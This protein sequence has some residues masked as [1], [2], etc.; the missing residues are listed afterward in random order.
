MVLGSVCRDYSKKQG[1]KIF[2]QNFCLGC[3]SAFEALSL[4]IILFN[5]FLLE[6]LK[7]GLSLNLNLI[8]TSSF[9]NDKDFTVKSRRIQV[10]WRFIHKMIRISAVFSFRDITLCWNLKIC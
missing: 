1:V 10:K 3:L 8:I 4:F 7:H 9:T 6:N 5:N 2:D